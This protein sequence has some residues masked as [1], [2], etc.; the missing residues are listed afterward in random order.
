MQF[1]STIIFT[2]GRDGWKSQREW[3]FRRQQGSP[4]KKWPAESELVLRETALPWLWPL[5]KYC[6]NNPGSQ[7]LRGRCEVGWDWNVPW[8]FSW[9][10]MGE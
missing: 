9:Y 7:N 8:A 10:L 4:W 1:L 6:S 2:G 3:D 5:V